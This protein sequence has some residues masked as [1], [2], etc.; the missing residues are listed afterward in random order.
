MSS[1][2]LA[3]LMLRLLVGVRNLDESRRDALKRFFLSA[4]QPDGGFR[5][6]RGDSDL[7]Y[8]AFALRGL[9]LLNAAGT[10]AVMELPNIGDFLERRDPEQWNA[11][12]TVSL[13]Y[14]LVLAAWLRGNE[15]SGEQ[16]ER[17]LRRLERFRRDDGGFATS[18]KTAYSSTYQT[19]LAATVFESL[20][21]G[22]RVTR[23]PVEPILERQRPDGGFVEL[24]PLRRSGTNP[25][26]AAIG[27][28]SMHGIR[29]R[30]ASATA[31]FLLA[32]QTP[33]GGFSAN[34]RLPVPDLLSSFTALVA[35][36]DLD[37]DNRCDR[38]SL[39]RFVGAAGAPDGGFYAA[40]WD[41]QSDVEYAFY[42]LALEALLSF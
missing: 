17:V 20:G 2:Y 24:A 9:F 36:G 1:H 28:L 35:L 31:D 27:F 42:G 3:S 18:E 41:R 10:D 38:E 23:I 39:R 21:A 11:A 12:E 13:A 37:A 8:T 5:G 15:P 7:Y 6:R 33:Q 40:P 4:R 22:D 25:T 34:A 19:F 29:P 30:S 32:R 26:A 14:G 16:K